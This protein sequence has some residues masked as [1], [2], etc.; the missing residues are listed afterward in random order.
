MLFA[1]PVFFLEGWLWDG[2]MIAYLNPPVVMALLYQS[3]P[4]ASVG[5]VVWN[6]LLKRYGASTLHSF[7]FIMPLT[8][9]ASGALL[10]HEPL[11]NKMVAAALLVA[12]G[13]GIV[14]S[15]SRVTIPALPIG[16]GG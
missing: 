10:L 12:V 3:L 14:N 1:T 8:G 5:F 13:I 4:T 6:T 11:T 2:V 7:I 9:V 16:K 15:K